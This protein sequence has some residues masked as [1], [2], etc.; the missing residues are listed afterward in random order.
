[1]AKL[2]YDLLLS[3]SSVTIGNE[4]QRL[5]FEKMLRFARDNEESYASYQ[6]IKN[7]HANLVSWGLAATPLGENLKH[8]VAMH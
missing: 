3:L 7:A 8:W 2:I 6:A 5:V 1:M 4:A